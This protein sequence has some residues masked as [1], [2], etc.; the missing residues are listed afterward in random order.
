MKKLI[1]SFIFFFSFFNG[2]FNNG[3]SDTKLYDT[4]EATIEID[5]ARIDKDNLQISWIIN[6][7]ENIDEVIL[8]VRELTPDGLL[9]EPLEF[10]DYSNQGQKIVEWD[11]T[12][13]LSITLKILTTNYTQYSGPDCDSVYCYRDITTEI[14]SDEYIINKIPELPG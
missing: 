14:T 1:I 10:S 8:S 12:T 9:G 2:V 13:N 6:G 11:G 3:Y 7:V 5:S 4:D